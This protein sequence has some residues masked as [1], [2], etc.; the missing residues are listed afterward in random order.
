MTPIE[1]MLIGLVAL[2]GLCSIAGLVMFFQQLF[3]YLEVR[4]KLKRGEIH[5]DDDEED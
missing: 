3:R 2:I 4:Q 5:F 1:W